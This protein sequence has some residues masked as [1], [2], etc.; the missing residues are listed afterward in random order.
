MHPGKVVLVSNTPYTAEH[1]EVVLSQLVDDKIE[2]FCAVGL[3]AEKWE[4]A[5]DW[6]CIGPDGKSLHFIVTTSHPD[7]SVEEVISFAETFHCNCTD[8]VEVIYV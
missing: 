4:D 1:G 7:E 2:L 6:L 8:E 5:L 3:D